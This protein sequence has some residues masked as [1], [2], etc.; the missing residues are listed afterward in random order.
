M[1]IDP[2]PRGRNLRIRKVVFL[3]SALTIVVLSTINI[4]GFCWARFDLA[5]INTMEKTILAESFRRYSERG[6]KNIADFSKEITVSRE[7]RAL[8]ILQVLFDAIGFKIFRFRV[9]IRD[10]E[11]DIYVD[12]CGN[13][14][15]VYSY[16]ERQDANNL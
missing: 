12:G 2:N 1:F 13:P 11:A 9:A 10:F 16:W 7:P 5:N 6:T 4:I 15:E 8:S 3:T 14:Q